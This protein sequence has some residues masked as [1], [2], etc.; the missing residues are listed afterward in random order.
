MFNLSVK[1][2]YRSLFKNI[3]WNDNVS[4]KV[5]SHPNLGDNGVVK[6]KEFWNKKVLECVKWRS[7]KCPNKYPVNH[8]LAQ[9]LYFYFE[10]S[11]MRIIDQIKFLFCVLKYL[12]ECRWCFSYLTIL[13]VFSWGGQKK[14][15]NLWKNT[16]KFGLFHSEVY[17]GTK[18]DCMKFHLTWYV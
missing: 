13:S 14:Q 6:K 16:F 12:N 18:K 11:R 8:S 17:I 10:N 7:Q 3:S 15:R 1:N 4:Y 2:I 9:M 5:T